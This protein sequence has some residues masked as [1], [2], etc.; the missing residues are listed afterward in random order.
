MIERNLLKYLI[1]DYGLLIVFFV[2]FTLPKFKV[3]LHTFLSTCEFR[4]MLSSQWS[5]ILNIY[6]ILFISANA[7]F[8]MTSMILK[9]LHCLG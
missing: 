6:H 2:I 3:T 5:F 1:M 4:I 9:Y 8:C 7:F